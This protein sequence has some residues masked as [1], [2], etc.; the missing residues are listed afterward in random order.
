MKEAYLGNCTCN[1]KRRWHHSPLCNAIYWAHIWI[2]KNVE[3]FQIS[4]YM[5][6]NKDHNKLLL[7]ARG[8]LA[9]QS[10]T[11][12]LFFSVNYNYFNSQHNYWLKY[13][14]IL[15]QK[16]Y[17]QSLNLKKCYLRVA[18]TVLLIAL[19]PKW[20]HRNGGWLA[21]GW[22]RVRFSAEAAPICLCK[23]LSGDTAL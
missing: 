5:H 7:V 4:L 11:T 15:C 6:W 13:D 2:N 22:L 9:P 16:V 17:L 3:E 20:P 12:F 21:C 8:N 1:L 14:N 23:W 10:M 18:S 19:F